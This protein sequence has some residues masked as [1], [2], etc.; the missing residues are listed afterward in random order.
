MKFFLSTAFV[1]LLSMLALLMIKPATHLGIKL[2]GYQWPVTFAHHKTKLYQNISEPAIVLVGGSN[3]LYGVDTQLMSNSLNKP[4]FNFGLGA[5][6]GIKMML[7]LTEVALKPGDIVVLSLENELLN[8]HP[9]STKGR[10]VN[11]LT[12]KELHQSLSIKE[13]LL[14][15]WLAPLSATFTSISDPKSDRFNNI[16]Q[17]SSLNP[18]GEFNVTIIEEN[19]PLK[20]FPA[21][22]MT[23]TYSIA[24]TNQAILDGFVKRMRK[25][26]ITVIATPAARYARVNSPETYY[27]NERDIKNMYIKL[28]VPYLSDVQHH[29]F[30]ANEMYDSANHINP[31]SRLT[32]TQHL[33]TAL[34]TF[35]GDSSSLSLN[36]HL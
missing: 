3:L 28:N 13:R 30:A 6:I 27:Q 16:Y 34:N 7:E 24:P 5:S 19:T 18:S 31:Q 20:P 25:N 10:V 23:G 22:Q 17:L 21:K 33:I 14:T 35:L 4:V 8:T 15:Y 32:N 36:H 2:N 29:S 1:G 9:L 11:A 26:N 12:I